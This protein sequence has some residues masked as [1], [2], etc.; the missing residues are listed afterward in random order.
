MGII[1]KLA[2]NMTD[3]EVFE[4][5][6]Q[7]NQ[8]LIRNLKLQLYCTILLEKKR[9]KKRPRKP[10]TCFV[11]D[12]IIENPLHGHSDTL[13]KTLLDTDKPT[14]RFSAGQT[15]FFANIS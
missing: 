7:Y 14:I 4:G 12:W 6:L 15:L 5:Q 1:D 3:D 13:M 9:D 2:T 11:R 8:M 10:R